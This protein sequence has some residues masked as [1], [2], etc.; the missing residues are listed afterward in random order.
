M[1]VFIKAACFPN[2]PQINKCFAGGFG[3]G[4]ANLWRADDC[5]AGFPF[6]PNPTYLFLVLPVFGMVLFQL[7][8][9]TVP[10]KG[11]IAKGLSASTERLLGLSKRLDFVFAAS[12]ENLEAAR[13]LFSLREGV[14][15]LHFLSRLALRVANRF[16]TG[17][18][19][20]YKHFV[21]HFLC[22]CV[23]YE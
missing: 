4:N 8:F 16:P 12:D 22:R 19:L 17:A 13:F 2:P 6:G 3:S 11:A 23:F 5:P 21:P 7:R 9:S 18:T 1:S 20:I 14:L 15:K 10:D